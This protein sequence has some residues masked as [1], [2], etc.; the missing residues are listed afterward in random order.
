MKVY[1]IEFKQTINCS[2]FG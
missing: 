2:S 1:N